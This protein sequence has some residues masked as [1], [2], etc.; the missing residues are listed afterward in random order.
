MGR[1][2][3]AQVLCR[4]GLHLSSATVGRM[5]KEPLRP[6][7]TAEA[8]TTA[9]V[10]TAQRPNHVW[11]LD[12]STVPISS[13]FWTPWLPWAL[14]QRWP[15]CWWLAV[16]LDHFS[17]AVIGFAL[18]KKQPTATEIR[19]FVRRAARKS[20]A[21]PNNLITDRGK[22]FTSKTF[23]RWCRKRDV[24]QRFGAV[25]QKGS[26]AVIERFFRTLKSE[27]TR[28]IFLSLRVATIREEMA[29]FATW[30]NQHRP[31][32]A[33]DGRT[34]AECAAGTVAESEPAQPAPNQRLHVFRALPRQARR[35]QTM[36]QALTTRTPY[37][38][39]SPPRE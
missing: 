17:R 19:D 28:R 29:L 23:R 39:E 18:F 35:R 9:R 20:G 30:Y 25:G 13:G 37:P 32:R 11:H 27:G 10:V 6:K 21:A 8:E 4:A 33:L 15:F 14:P 24:R 16:V 22:Q 38:V 2:K 1:V 5:L 12:L 34:P 3:I 31:H 26:I 36:F 7:P